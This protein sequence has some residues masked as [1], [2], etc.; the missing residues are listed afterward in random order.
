MKQYILETSLDFSVNYPRKDLRV[1]SLVLVLKNESESQ[2]FLGDIMGDGSANFV[3]DQEFTI[4]T[5][6]G[7]GAST[8]TSSGL[9]RKLAGPLDVDRQDGSSTI[10]FQDSAE[11][12][13][14]E[15]L[16]NPIGC[17][18]L[19]VVSG[20]GAGYTYDV[21]R[22]REDALDIV[23]TFEVNLD[24]TSVID[25]RV[26]EDPELAVGEPSRVYTPAPSLLKK[27][28]NYEVT[29][30]LHVIAGQQDHVIYLYSVVK[31]LLLSQRSFLE[32]Q[33]VQAMRIGGSDFAPRS[34]YLPDEIF[35]RAMTLTFTYPFSFLEEQD[36][37]D[38]IQVNLLPEP[39]EDPEAAV[40][41]G[42]P[43]TLTV[44]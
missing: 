9:P 40:L 17:L 41:Q 14:A 32:S 28:V 19:Y 8:S 15:L 20:S 6:G 42:Y 18:K 39:A 1:P 11:D 26:P 25:L 3:P 22:I 31:A 30:Q 4:D 35:Q 34:E 44:Y 21:A 13:V 38:Q 37:F 24:E 43:I 7:H 27:G 16:E 23:G 29:Y 12:I 2:T 36:T 5:L 33:G 10:F